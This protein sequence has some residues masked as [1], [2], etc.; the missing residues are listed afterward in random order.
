VPHVQPGDASVNGKVVLQ[1]EEEEEDGIVNSGDFEFVVDDVIPTEGSGETR[2]M[3]EVLDGKLDPGV[4]LATHA[5]TSRERIR[6]FVAAA[7]EGV[8]RAGPV[9]ICF[10]C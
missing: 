1:S 6:R 3:F 5:V 2:V 4:K 8:K 10:G 7:R 9:V